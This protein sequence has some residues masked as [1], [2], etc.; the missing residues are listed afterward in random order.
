MEEW[1]KDRTQLVR[2][3]NLTES[4]LKAKISPAH[5]LEIKKFISW[6]EV[7]AYLKLGQTGLND[8]R[9]DGSSASDKRRRLIDLWEQ[10]NGDDATYDVMITAMLRAEQKSEA[11]EVCQLGEYINFEYSEYINLY[12][13]CLPTASQGADPATSPSP[14]SAAAVNAPPVSKPN[15]NPPKPS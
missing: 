15:P 4:R 7:G 2:D 11:T 3:H 6:Q 5:M 1:E 8:I 10:K 13:S 9:E 12:L 14:R